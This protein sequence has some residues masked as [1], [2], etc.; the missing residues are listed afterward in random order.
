MP[1]VPGQIGNVFGQPK[2][3]T[4]QFPR[5]AP[6]NPV[7]TPSGAGPSGP[8]MTDDMM[9][10][11]TPETAMTDAY[12]AL[13][14]AYPPREQPG[15]VDRIV[16]GLA[17]ITNPK[18]VEN[19]FAK[20]NQRR[21]DWEDQIKA[22]QP[23][24]LQERETNRI[25]RQDVTASNTNRIQRR[26]LNE[27]ERKNKENER[28]RADRAA[29]YRMKN[30]RKDWKL[31]NDDETGNIIAYNP[32]NPEETQFVMT[33]EGRPVKHGDLSD[34]DKI[35]AQV[36]G[37]LSQIKERG[38]QDRL[39]QSQRPANSRLQSL[40]DDKGGVIGTY[41]VDGKNK[42]I[43]E[44]TDADLGRVSTT[45]PPAG[46]GAGESQTQ[47]RARI[48]NNAQQAVNANPD[49]EKFITY[50]PD[51]MVQLE[52]PESPKWYQIFGSSKPAKEQYEK[53]Y[54][55]IYGEKPEQTNA[56]GPNNPKPRINAVPPKTTI[57]KVE[58]KVEAPK[59]RVTAY[60]K[61]GKA[62]GT[63]P[64]TPEQRAEA[65]KQGYTVK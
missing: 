32:N 16:A 20:T 19:M 54:D 24:M 12:N 64:D 46:S 37:S 36:E 61:S 15:K 21:A 43:S 40:Y 65:A 23:A 6:I 29:V 11:Y 62:V 47:R 59:G 35:D 42:V 17:S 3:P 8:A 25:A 5:P 48:F 58:S 31:A 18:A 30:T 45:R 57:P 2:Q 1:I 63:I 44:A 53:L 51:G 33:P 10:T 27:E 22:T 9:E 7:M 56:A 38:A 39:T 34:E 28:V 50:K 14:K 60:D 26:K 49:Y 41:W 55:L 52:G 13:L 4:V